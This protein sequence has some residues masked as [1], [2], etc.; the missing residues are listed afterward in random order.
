MGAVSQCC[1]DHF[2]GIRQ[3]YHADFVPRRHNGPDG[4]VAEAH[5]TRDHFLFSGL[6]DARVFR[7]ND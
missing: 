3:I 4:K 6:Q 1:F 5:H 2:G 7:F